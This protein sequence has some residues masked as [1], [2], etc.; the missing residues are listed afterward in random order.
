M[1]LV[2]CCL[3]PL[4]VL[5]E[6]YSVS[7]ALTGT[8]IEIIE[9]EPTPVPKAVKIQWE[10][11]PKIVSV[12]DTLKITSTLIGFEEV[13]MIMYEWQVNR[14]DGNDYITLMDE[15]GPTLTIVA[16]KETLSYEYR[17]VVHWE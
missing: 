16:T 12:G 5:A 14:H 10:N 4:S 17:L 15:N 9:P 3:H 7:D 1:L 11:Y 8:E 13:S 6:D 2:L